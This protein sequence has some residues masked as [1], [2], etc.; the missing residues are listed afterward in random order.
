MEIK[1][2]M[3]WT[4]VATDNQVVYTYKNGWFTYLVVIPVLCVLASIP[5]IGWGILGLWIFYWYISPA[6]GRELRQVMKSNQVSL[7]GQRFSSKNPLTVTV[8]R[9]V[10]DS[11]VNKK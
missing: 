8:D 11:V 9:S 4:R 2:T 10:F 7:K 6:P 1:K 3:F 5:V